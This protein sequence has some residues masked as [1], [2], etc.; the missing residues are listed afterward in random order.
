M[1]QVF[2]T[3]DMEE[4]VRALAGRYERVLVRN[5]HVLW[6]RIRL[7]A[8]DLA[9]LEPRVVRF[10]PQ[11]ERELHDWNRDGGLLLYG[12]DYQHSENIAAHHAQLMVE[13]PLNRERFE[14]MIVAA[15]ELVVVYMPPSWDEHW[16][17]V[18][19][20]NPDATVGKRVYRAMKEG[21]APT[22]A[23][24]SAIGRVEAGCIATDKDLAKAAGVQPWE[25]KRMR[26]IM[27]IWREY[28]MVNQA[29]LRYP[30]DDPTLAQA[31]RFIERECPK[32][33]GVH[34]IVKTKL[35]KAVRFWRA[36]LRDL[37]RCGS[38]ALREELFFYP[39]DGL[40]PDWQ[41][42]AAIHESARSRF[43]AMV[44]FLQQTPE[45]NP[46]K[47]SRSRARSAPSPRSSAA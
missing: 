47:K 45:F 22:P 11:W 28:T 12:R 8:V 42:M 30:P 38:I 2:H 3:R 18:R 21:P 29:I 5:Y 13:C 27:L 19:E 44:E 17:A 37:E 6:K 23:V 33:D 9:D 10:A 46:P 24:L 4:A 20:L 15:R 43:T 39:L 14:R 25:V 1:A 35:A 36:A 40:P 26:N 41:K 16:R 7:R 32:V 34:L 31:Y